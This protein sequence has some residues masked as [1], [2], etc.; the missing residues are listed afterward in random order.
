MISKEAYRKALA[1]H[2]CVSIEDLSPNELALIDRAYFIFEGNMD[3]L[4]VMVDEVKRLNIELVNYKAMY[5]EDTRPSNH[6]D[7]GDENMD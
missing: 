7:E 5:N 3:E 1:D 2:I 6:V 4:K